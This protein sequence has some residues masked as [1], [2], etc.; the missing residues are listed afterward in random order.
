MTRAAVVLLGTVGYAMLGIYTYVFEWRPL[1]NA[2]EKPVVPVV[3]VQPRVSAEFREGQFVLSGVVPD[4]SLQSLLGK[5]A[6][7]IFGAERVDVPLEVSP[8]VE[9]GGWITGIADVL[10]KMDGGKWFEA[11]LEVRDGMVKLTGVAATA[12][13]RAVIGAEVQVALQGLTMD[14]R[15]EVAMPESAMMLQARVNRELFARRIRFGD[16]MSILT[17]TELQPLDSVVGLLRGADKP[18][19]EVHI[20]AADQ[21]LGQRRADAVRAYLMARGVAAD[22]VGAKGKVG[23]R[24]WMEIEVLRP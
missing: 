9:A 20:Y 22:R 5:S 19:F 16:G 7:A 24:E 8:K 21:G 6:K 2:S 3:K 12:A 1:V 13:D 4:E 14:N 17:P 11:G 10:P 15:I 18:K 23:T